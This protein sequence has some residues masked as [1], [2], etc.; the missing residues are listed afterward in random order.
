EETFEPLN[1]SLFANHLAMQFL[2]KVHDMLTLTGLNDENLLAH[3]ATTYST[4]SIKQLL[5]HLLESKQSS[6]NQDLLQQLLHVLNG[7][8][9]QSVV[10][11]KNLLHARLVI[12]GA[13]L[14]LNNH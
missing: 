3:A 13:P 1:K 10:E 6:L 2:H 12:L 14:L 9:L 7:I 8:Q 4:S 11:T 5:L